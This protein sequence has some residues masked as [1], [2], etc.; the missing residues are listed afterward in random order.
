VPGA[1]PDGSK[2][3]LAPPQEPAWWSAP[4]LGSVPTDSLSRVQH[5]KLT[6]WV[7][8]AQPSLF[9]LTNDEKDGVAFRLADAVIRS[10]TYAAQK[11]L[12]GRVST[13][14]MHIRSLLVALLE[15]SN[16]LTPTLAATAM[17]APLSALRG[18]VAHAQRLLNVEG[19]AVLR[20]DADGETLIL[21]EALLR[22]QF[23][24]RA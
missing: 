12:A 9:P 8:P 20:R 6:K 10:G 23:E 19:Y 13:T 4:N 22:E 7:V 5:P 16:R 1:V 15:G 11:R 18:A 14:D 17:E 2:L 3:R 24:V 21:D